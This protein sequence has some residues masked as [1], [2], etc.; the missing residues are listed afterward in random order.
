MKVRLIFTVGISLLENARQ[1]KKEKSLQNLATASKADIIRSLQEADNSTLATLETENIL[2]ELLRKEAPDISAETH[3]YSKLYRIGI[4][5]PSKNELHVILLGTEGNNE[6]PGSIQCARH[7]ES[8]IKEKWCPQKIEIDTVSGGIKSREAFKEALLGLVT[9]LQKHFKK[10]DVDET[11]VIITGGFKGFIPWL[12]LTTVLYDNTYL[13]YVHENSNEVLRWPGLYLHW[14]LRRLDELRS[15]IRR[16]ELNSADWEMLPPP[17]KYLY[18]QDGTRY[19]MNELGQMIREFFEQNRLARYGYGRLL[20]E[21]LKAKGN[22]GEELA[23]LIEVRLPY[24][25]HL[26]IGDQIPE[27][28]EHSRLHSLRLMEYAYLLLR[29]FPELEEKLSAEQLFYLIAALW[30]HDVGHGALLYDGQPIGKMPSLIREYH[31]LTSAKIIRNEEGYQILPTEALLPNEHK[32]K[33]ALMAEYNRRRQPLTRDHKEALEQE[34]SS[35]GITAKIAAP[36]ADVD[37]DLLLVTA[38]LGLLDGLDV[39]RDRTVTPYYLKMREQRTRYEIETHLKWLGLQIE[40]HDIV[41]AL[42]LKQLKKL[43]ERYKQNSEDLNQEL[44]EAIKA[45]E[46]LFSEACASGD[47]AK[48]EWAS[49]ANRILFKMNQRQHVAKHGAVDL[50]YLNCD[51]DGALRINLLPTDAAQETDLDK[52][53]ADIREEVVRALYVDDFRDVV[54]QVRLYRLIGDEMKRQWSEPDQAEVRRN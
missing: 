41:D 22:K 9:K 47:Q 11:Y 31:N 21:K 4:A 29:Y 39:Q 44:E 43:Y 19:R 20:L 10:G 8:Y 23:E 24:W 40:P 25:E 37:N 54:K 14:D 53:E 34:N 51:E 16:S 48:M 50:V 17:A 5:D 45:S 36:L 2:N 49:L 32:A 42:K 26:W 13:V 3:S 12:T 18:D 30:L 46:E 38:L 33:V 35:K 52:V 1:L 15:I 6:E 27:T 7:L 28:V